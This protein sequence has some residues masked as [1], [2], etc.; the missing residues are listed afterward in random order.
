MSVPLIEDSGG[1]V[2]SG[3]SGSEQQFSSTAS[4][5]TSASSAGSRLGRRDLLTVHVGNG[6]TISK[7][8]LE[9]LLVVAQTLILLYWVYTEVTT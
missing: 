4:T 8:D 2:A 3:S 6:V 9:L 5:S 1:A 7:E